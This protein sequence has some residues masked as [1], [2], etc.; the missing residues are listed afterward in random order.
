V[1]CPRSGTTLLQALLD[2]HT[3]IAV[4]PESHFIPRLQRRFGAG[5]SGTARA[6][7][8]AA[9]L[10]DGRRF[11]LWGISRERVIELVD[12]GRPTDVAGAVR[13]LFSEW[14]RRAGKPGYADKTP[15]YVRRIGV[16]GAQFPEARFVHL[17][18]DGRDV[19]LSLAQS[20]D[21][22]PQT[23]AQAAL[24]WSERVRAGR[25]Q[26]AAL[27]SG[28]YLELRYEELVADP[29]ATVRTLT[30]FL[31]IPYEAAMLERANVDR[32][33]A[34]YPDPSVHP[35]LAGPITHRRDW[36]REM[37]AA[38]RRRFE[39][40]AGPL[41]EELG[42]EV[43]DQGGAD[44]VEAERKRLSLLGAELEQLRHELFRARRQARQTDARLE[45]LRA[46]RLNRAGAALAGAAARLRGGGRA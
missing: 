2:S 15:D 11:E 16:L 34:G 19:A 30:E 42:Y 37:G 9:A 12:E 33:L 3:A 4:P 17:I 43:A 20:F 22:A 29:E 28:R 44:P 10:F 45:R 8:F 13:L 24:Y 38:E 5:W 39:L 18:R 7:R 35:H 27:P 26:G 14:A 23:P 32:V 31:E 40:L 46:S 1:G 36:R 6:R 21:R 25:A 41:L